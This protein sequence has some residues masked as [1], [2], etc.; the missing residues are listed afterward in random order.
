[1]LVDVTPLGVTG[2]EA[3]HLLDEI[4]ITVNKNAI[5]FDTLPPNTA[6]GIR[7]GTPATT[8]R[9]FGPD[10][11]RD[12]RADH[13]RGDPR[14]RRAGGP[15]PPGRRGPRDRRAASR[16]PAC[17]P[18]ETPDG[19]AV[20]P[21]RQGA[22]D[23]H[24]DRRQRH[25]ADRRRRSS[26]AAVLAL[27][28]TPVVRRDRPA[29][30][31]RRST[32]GPPG[33][34]DPGAARRRAG[35]LRRVPRCVAGAFL[36]VNHERRGSCRCRSASRRPRSRRCCSA[37]PWRPVSAPSTTCS[38]SGRA[39]SCSARSR[40][41]CGAVALGITHRLHRQPVRWPADPFA[42]SGSVAAGLTI[43]WIVGMINSINWIDGLDGLSSG[44]R[45]HRRGDAGHH[46]PDDPGRPASR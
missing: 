34:H 8:S 14:P 30:R 5:P 24:P 32:R 22:D 20:D 31:D 4:G 41:A 13:H 11:M 17:R 7:I 19:L 25:R 43:F 39:A 46:Q 28:L 27:V 9:G 42:R 33:Q 10:E 16:C 15:G 38:T 40:L 36:L 29:L 1:M 6:S 35:G 18:R 2:K 45:V 26:L 21:S 23:L 37:A 3:E 44:R 12:D